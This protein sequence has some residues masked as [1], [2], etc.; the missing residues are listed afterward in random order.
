MS[1]RDVIRKLCYYNGMY[2]NDRHNPGIDGDDN[3]DV[4]DSVR[5]LYSAMLCGVGNLLAGSCC[6][7][8]SDLGLL[9]S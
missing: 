6:T 3:S 4:V 1:F 5:F 9:P 2:H 8:A 7:L